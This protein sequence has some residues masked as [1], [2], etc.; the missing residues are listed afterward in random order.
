MRAVSLVVL[1]LSTSALLGGSAGA[2]RS[3]LSV[4]VTGVQA[5]P[6]SATVSWQVSA[7]A[8]V[9]V[10]YGLSGRLRSVVSAR[11]V[12]ARTAS[13]RPASPCSSRAGSTGSA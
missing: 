1:A 3:G 13:A 2:A 11:R 8:S 6:Y 9:V 12:R 10:E 4:A 7:P 5:G